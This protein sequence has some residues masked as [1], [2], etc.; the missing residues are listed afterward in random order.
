M[1]MHY[2]EIQATTE[3]KHSIKHS[4]EAGLHRLRNARER[5]MSIH[6]HGHRHQSPHAK[7]T[8]FY[9]DIDIDI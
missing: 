7:P 8:F 6:C 1:H 9:Q 2:N 3:G 5:P 4:K